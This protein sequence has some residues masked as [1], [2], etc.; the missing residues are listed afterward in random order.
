M[1]VVGHEVLLRAF[2]EH[3]KKF[4]EENNIDYGDGL[5]VSGMFLK[6]GLACDVWI[7]LQ[8]ASSWFHHHPKHWITKRIKNCIHRIKDNRKL[9]S[10]INSN[11]LSTIVMLITLR[12]DLHIHFML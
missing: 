11:F 1:K 10:L 2:V 4:K 3:H 6:V 8:R 5:N 9:T 7:V 12:I